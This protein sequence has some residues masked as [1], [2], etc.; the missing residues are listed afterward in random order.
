MSEDVERL[1][2]EQIRYYDD[3]A[4][5]YED[6]WY[7]RGA[8][9]RGAEFNE[10]WF[11]QTAAAEAAVEAVEIGGPVLE[12]ACGSGLWTRHLAPRA[13]RY[14][15]VDASPSML[16]LN[17]ELTGVP[18]IEYVCADVFEWSPSEGERFDLIF[19]GFF[20]SHVPPTR[21]GPLWERTGSW[22][23]SG[24]RVVFIDDRAGPDRPRSGTPVEGGPTFANRRRLADGRE[25]TVV[26]VFYEPADLERAIDGIGW[27]ADVVTFGDHFLF[28]T[29]RPSRDAGDPP[30]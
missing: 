4:P 8:Y 1:L 28:G 25:Y 15:A 7:R 24:G 10:E 16:E 14:V 17:R 26:K 23:A 20:L 5:E 22:L 13:E 30:V 11:R 12:V 29:A 2:A 21:F 6:L 19:I 9:D 27:D 3:R 18:R